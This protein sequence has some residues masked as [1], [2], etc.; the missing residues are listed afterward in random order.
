MNQAYINAFLHIK[1][2]AYDK[3]L[4]PLTIG[5]SLILDFISSPFFTGRPIQE[6]D[7]IT[8][9]F[10]CSMNF[11]KGLHYLTNRDEM[12]DDIQ[13][14]SK[15]LSK[16]NHDF[17]TELAVFNKYLEYYM[18]FPRRWEDSTGKDSKVPWQC[19]IIYLLLEKFS[20][21]DVM[22]MPLTK[23][24]C[25][26][27]CHNNQMGENNLAGMEQSELLDKWERDEKDEMNNG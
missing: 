10:F 19:S 14:W 9:I 12:N 17:E 2:V 23:A 5:H 18:T 3:Q 24:M 16:S 15:Q 7:L 8:A 13:K 21:S 6:S 11:E 4:L 1:P 22:N 26:V 27:A 25:W 20:E